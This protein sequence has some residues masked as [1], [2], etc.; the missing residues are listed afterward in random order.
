MMRMSWQLV[1]RKMMRN[2]TWRKLDRRKLHGA[3]W[4]TIPC[5]TQFI[6]ITKIITYLL[7]G[8]FIILFILSSYNFFYKCILYFLPLCC[9]NILYINIIFLKNI[10]KL[11]FAKITNAFINWCFFKENAS[12]LFFLYIYFVIILWNLFHFLSQDIQQAS[13]CLLG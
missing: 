6:T 2:P 10:L 3:I 5:L 9:F 8:Y 13:S 11:N 7:Y 4:P 1:L 12:L